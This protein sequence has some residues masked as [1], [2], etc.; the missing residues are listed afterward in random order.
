[1]RA[2][3]DFSALRNDSLKKELTDHLKEIRIGEKARLSIGGEWR[4]QYQNY[5]QAN[6]GQMPATFTEES[7]HQWLHR[8]LL[9][10]D[11][12]VNARFRIYI[13]LNNT[14][15]FWNPNPI[16]SQ[17]EQNLLSVHQF[18]GEYKWNQKFQVRVGKQEMQLGQERFIASREGPN[19][20]QTFLGAEASYTAKKAKLMLFYLNPIKMNLGAFD[21]GLMDEQI[22]GMYVAKELVPKKLNLDAFYFNFTST[23]R[24]YLF[25]NGLERRHTGGIRLYAPLK[26]FNYEL[27]LAYQW[28]TF[29][30][31]AIR[32]WMLVWDTNYQL[33]PHLFLGIGGNY[34]PGDKSTTDSELNTFNTLFA[35]PPFGQTVALNITNT[36]NISPY[37]RFQKGA[38]WLVTARASFVNRLSEEDGIYTPN[39]SALRPI[40]NGGASTKKDLCSIYALDF[41]Y[42]TA[43]HLFTQVEVGYCQAGDYLKESGSGKNVVYFALRNAYRF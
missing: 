15:R 3:D 22:G 27:E 6:F 43:P 13:Q 11:L 28:G 40:E 10:A 4:E 17:V 42:N 36:L 18:F 5:T 33:K 16:L 37:V 1:M 31:L 26:T 19:N 39:M 21:D 35:R 2:E 41:N 23:Q 8:W 7:P 38:R 24:T 34:V 32:S 25:K 14:V 9:H 30:E 12:R 29:N 20:R